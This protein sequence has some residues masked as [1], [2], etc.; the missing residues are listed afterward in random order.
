MTAVTLGTFPLLYFFTFLYY[1]DIGSTFMVL[2]M[3]YFSVCNWHFV[4]ALTGYIAILFRQS[5]FAWVVFTAGT[6]AARMLLTGIQ[7]KDQKPP[8]SLI[9]TLK[10]FIWFVLGNLKEFIGLLWPYAITAISFVMFVFIN[11]GIVVGDRSSHE[12]CL[13]FPQF[14]YLLGFTLFFS[15]PHLISPSIVCNFL[16]N[17]RNI[18]RHPIKLLAFLLTILLM[19]FLIFKFTYVHKYLLADNRHYPFYVWRKLYGRHWTVKYA[20]IPVYL[21]SGWGVHHLLSSRQHFLWHLVFVVCVAMVTVPQK[22]LEFRYFIMPY[23]MYRIHAPL[24]SRLKLFLEA[25]FYAAIN[26]AT[27]YLFLEK[28]FHWPHEPQEVQ[29]FMW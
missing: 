6:A 14:F 2:L 25:A 5:N 17:V 27:L 11:K 26:V 3:Y 10:K 18:F 8:T 23:V 7:D 21:Y 16:S 1:T 12:S 4:A 29:R 22:L 9:S 24:A 13:N 19:F 15:W 20:L 28:P